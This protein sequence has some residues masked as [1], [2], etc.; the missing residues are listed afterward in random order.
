MVSGNPGLIVKGDG[1]SS[2]CDEELQKASYF[3]VDVFFGFPHFSTKDTSLHVNTFQKCKF[4]LIATANA[5]YLRFFK[6]RG[7]F[8]QLKQRP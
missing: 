8:P 1:E 2:E 5:I 7:Y 6:A 4:R 3:F